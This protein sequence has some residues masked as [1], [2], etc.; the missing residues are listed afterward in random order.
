MWISLSDNVHIAK[1]I[2]DSG[3]NVNI[4]T[5]SGTPLHS[6]VRSSSGKSIP[7]RTFSA[8]LSV[9]QIK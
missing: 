4:E 1:L 7:F 3:A 5:E 2:I 9:D 6:A 8:Q